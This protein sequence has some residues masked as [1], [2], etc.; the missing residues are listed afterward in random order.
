[1]ARKDY[2]YLI[3][4]RFGKLE[5]IG[6]CRIDITNRAPC[7]GVICKCDC[8]TIGYRCQLSTIRNGGTKSCGCLS[9][10]SMVGA[11]FNRLTILSE[12]I[13]LNEN[14]I[15]IYS[16]CRCDCGRI[17]IAIKSAIVNGQTKSCGCIK[18]KFTERSKAKAMRSSW[19]AMKRRCKDE[20]G[21]HYKYYKGKGI[22]YCERWSRFPHFYEDMQEGWK[23]GLEL[24]R[25]ENDKGYYKENCRWATHFQ[26][27]RNKTSNKL[28]EF[29][30][31]AIRESNLSPQELG[32]IYNVHYTT[33][34][35]VKNMKRW[36]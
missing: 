28:T 4:Q 14:K 32:R 29:D 23:E 30:V 7:A 2:S 34:G 19:A 11:K 27:Q 31:K 21:K 1:M 25:I 10:K 3:G 5:I 17:T 9:Y 13:K 33:I 20:T 35:R 6:L 36:A 8:G 26:Q 12:F 22:N 24:D 16:E 18:I 15:R